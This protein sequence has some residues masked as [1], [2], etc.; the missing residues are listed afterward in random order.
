M[1]LNDRVISLQILAI[2]NHTFKHCVHRVHEYQ[3]VQAQNVPC[4]VCLEIRVL[5]CIV[6]TKS[7]SVALNSESVMR[8]TTRLKS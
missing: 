8:G 6:L 7:K 2:T 1:C 3:F 4:R 5:V